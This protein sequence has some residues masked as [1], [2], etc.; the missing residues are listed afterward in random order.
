MSQLSLMLANQTNG[1]Y[2]QAIAYYNQLKKQF[3]RE[4]QMAL[5]QG[6]KHQSERYVNDFIEEINSGGLQGKSWNLVDSLTEELENAL[7]EALEKK[8]KKRFTKL[9]QYSEKSYGELTKKGRETLEYNLSKI[10]D[11]N[12]IHEILWQQLM[13]YQISQVDGVDLS[14]LVA[15]AKSYVLSDFFNRQL[16]QKAGGTANK[17]SAAGYFE[18][19]LVHKATSKLTSHLESKSGSLMVGSTKK[20]VASGKKIDTIFDEYFNFFSQDLKQS[21]KESLSIDNNFLSSGFGAQVKLYNLPGNIKN[22]RASYTVSSNVSLYN[23]WQH[24]TQWTKGVLFLAKHIR[25]ALGDNVMY[26]TGSTFSWT[27]DLISHFRNQKYF[28][29]FRFTSPQESTPTIAWEKVQAR[30]LTK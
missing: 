10:F 6:K 20:S 11:I 13:K 23:Q 28:L 16:L 3:M 4:Y 22:P 26:I 18:E 30:K 21:F 14:D 8:G 5:N 1:D 9:K 24:Q 27:A 12:Q 15:W 2:E 19:A 7:T 29:A 25:E 17:A